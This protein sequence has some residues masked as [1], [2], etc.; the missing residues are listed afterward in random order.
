MT[1]TPDTLVT[2]TVPLTDP[3][4]QYGI[5]TGD[6]AA[7]QQALE[8][9]CQDEWPPDDVDITVQDL[10]TTADTDTTE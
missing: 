1:D 5:Y 8:K 2:I 3:D 9:L 10:T 6:G 4:D 7:A